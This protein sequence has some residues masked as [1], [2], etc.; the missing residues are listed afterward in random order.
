MT[1]NHMVIPV[2][3]E[4]A[5]GTIEIIEKFTMKKMIECLL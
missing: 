3:P 1:I 4:E 5:P 2:E